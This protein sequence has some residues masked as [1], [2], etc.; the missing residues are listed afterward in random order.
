MNTAPLESNV[1]AN[2]VDE[3]REQYSLGRI[4]GIAA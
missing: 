3:K 2:V 1:R 4:L